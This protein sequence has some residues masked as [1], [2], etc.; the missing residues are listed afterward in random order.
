[1]P[2]SSPEK[3][4]FAV[5][6]Q[7]I[8]E[9]VMMRSP[10]FY[11]MAVRRKNGEIVVSRN[12]YISLTK[13]SK[14]WALPILRGIAVLYESVK[15]GT[16]ALLFSND[17]M[18]ADID[19]EKDK[20][21]AEK[22]E[23]KKTTVTAV[24]SKAFQPD[25]SE[26]PWWKKA[27]VVMG[28]AL[29]FVF[30]FAVA[31]FLFKFLPL[32]VADFTSRYAE[33]VSETYWLF[34]LIDGMT[35]VAIFLLYISLISLMPDVRR[36]FAYHGA[37]HQAIWAYEKGKEL[38]VKKAQ[39]EHPEHPRC[40][41]SFIVLVLMISVIVYTFLPSDDDFVIKLLQRV[42]VIPLLAGLSYEVLRISA[43]YET[44]WW[45]H[46]VT[47]P[48]IWLQKITT[49]KPTDDMEEVA[50]AAIKDALDAEE[51]YSTS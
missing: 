40:G 26:D 44:K 29:Y 15:L 50:L 33:V 41:T 5:G 22:D 23:S 25:R 49:R 51:H 42:A 4:N 9:G 19:A 13:R 32:L 11:V 27:L 17:V 3:I 43:K 6:G 20:K 45:M 34:N 16:R 48:G 36:V 35:K 21:K 2:K 28:S 39:E 14:F 37:E 31:I 46:W 38:T 30:I 10:H 47:I 24:D 12:E 1:M 8:L 7:A 18:F